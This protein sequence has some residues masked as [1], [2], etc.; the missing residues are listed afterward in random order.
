MT[1][2]EKNIYKIINYEGVL[3]SVLIRKLNFLTTIV[4]L[5]EQYGFIHGCYQL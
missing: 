2:R 1:N 4:N 3:I 5:D